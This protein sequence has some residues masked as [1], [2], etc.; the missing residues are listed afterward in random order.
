[1]PEPLP[2]S[3]YARDVLTVARDLLGRIL[4][5]ESPDGLT[6]GR[7]VEVEAYRGPADRVAHSY[8]G[9]RTRRTEVMYWAAGHAYIF[10]IHG[11]IDCLNIVTGEVEEPQAVLVRALEPL[12]GIELME[13][14]RGLTLQA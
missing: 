10:R 14:R 13:V 9:R 2:R 3:F 6:S 11:R 8:G 5:R 1:M 12:E 4:V 7:L